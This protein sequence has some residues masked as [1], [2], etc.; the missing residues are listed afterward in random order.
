MVNLYECLVSVTCSLMEFQTE[1]LIAEM[2]EQ[3]FLLSLC[4]TVHFCKSLVILGMKPRAGGKNRLLS[5]IN[6]QEIRTQCFI[7]HLCHDSQ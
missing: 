6:C 1:Y 5:L 7:N 3:I 2:K 4:I